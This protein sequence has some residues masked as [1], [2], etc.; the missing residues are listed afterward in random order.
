ME[1]PNTTFEG[2]EHD[3]SASAIHIRIVQIEENFYPFYIRLDAPL[4]EN[5]EQIKDSYGTGYSKPTGK[6]LD[7]FWNELKKNNGKEKTWK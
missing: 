6:I 5:S 7:T 3:R 2:E 1:A 4:L